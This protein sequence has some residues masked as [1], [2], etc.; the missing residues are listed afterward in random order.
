MAAS[1]KIGDQ[2]DL[3]VHALSHDG[4]AVGRVLDENDASARGHVVFVP[5]ALPGQR[6]R[7]RLTAV[8]KSFAEG[9]LVAVLTPAP[10][11]VPPACPHADDC[12]GCP[13]QEMP[14]TAQLQWKQRILSD[15]LTRIGRLKDLTIRDIMPSPQEW[16]YRNKMEFAFAS[17][18]QG[19]LY[20]GLR[21]RGS[22]EVVD[23][24]HCKLLPEPAMKVLAVMRDLA[25]KSGLDS[26]DS[27]GGGSGF[28]RFLVLRMPQS[29]PV[30]EE[31]S[32]LARQCLVYCITSRRTATEHVL[33]KDLGHALMAAVPEVTGFV[34]EVRDSVDNVPMGEKSLCRL[35]ED[36]LTEYLGGHAYAVG[37]KSFFQV[38]SGAAENLCTAVEEGAGL[39]GAEVLWD[40]YCGVGAPGLSIAGKAARVYGIETSSQAVDM[41]R[42][43]AETA[44]YSHCA[45][46]VGEAQILLRRLAGPHV[47]LVDPPRGGLHSEVVKELLRAKPKRI[48]YVSCNPATLARDAALL[49]RAGYAIGMV[50]AVDLFPQTPHVEAVM[51]FDAVAG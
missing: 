40:V 17:N 28:W 9:H 31:K 10:D 12:G 20:L 51:V 42:K 41:A 38:N 8:K 21:Q 29:M 4:R 19:Q 24:T 13:L 50:Q 11:A 22:H 36:V 44:G 26:W 49:V 14:Y 5:G 27:D 46:A 1:S 2:C 35:G 6:V 16:G 33:V 3:D 37:C 32:A 43:N 30:G 15:A 39:S 25:A 48:V 7:V 34:H 45:Y 23:I 18:V 47:V